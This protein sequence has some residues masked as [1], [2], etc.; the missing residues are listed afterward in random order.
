MVL[1]VTALSVLAFLVAFGALGVVAKAREAITISRAAGQVMGD[2]GLDDDA[3][4]AAVQKAALSLMKSFVGLLAR[5]AGILLAAY[6][7]IFAA[8]RA[9]L[10]SETAVLDFML[11]LDVIVVTTVVV[12]AA[13]WLLARLRGR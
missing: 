10:A 1:V 5:I 6:A 2:S 7:P 9:G 3:K 11:R 8:D 13:V 12:I 4:E